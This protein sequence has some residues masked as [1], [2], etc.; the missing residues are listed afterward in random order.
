M[1]TNLHQLL[2]ERPVTTLPQVGERLGNLLSKLGIYQVKDLLFHLPYRYE[3][4]T[5]TTP[6]A[7]L[8]MRETALVFGEIVAVRTYHKPRRSLSIRIADDTGVMFM[9]LFHYSVHQREAFERGGWIRCFGEAKY[10]RSYYEMIHPEYKIFP[11][12]QTDVQSIELTPVYRLTEGIRQ[13]MM[14]RTVKKALDAC[15]R[16][17]VPDLL[18]P[19]L[20]HN[21]GF[22]TLMEAIR[23]VHSPPAEVQESKQDFYEQPAMKRLIMEELTSFQVARKQQKALRQSKSAPK[24]LPKGNLSLRLKDSLHFEPTNSQR[25]VI[26]EIISDL[27]KSIPMQRLVQGD[28][29]SG[30]TLVAAA[31]AAWVVD[32]GY[33]VA[34]MAP[35][36][37]LAE[38]HLTS[39]L[40]WFGPLGVDVHLLKG[41]L[42]AKLRRDVNAAIKFGKAN[43]VIGTHAL[44][45]KDVE[46]GNLGLIIVDEQHRF[47]VGQR[48]ALR[49]KGVL[50]NSAPH[51]LIMTATPIPRTLAMTFYAELDVSSITELPP[52]RTPVTTQI[53]SATMRQRVFDDIERRCKRGEQ[54]YW[55]CPIIEQSEYLEAAAAMDAEKHLKKALPNRKVGLIHGRMK[56]AQ[57]DRIMTSFRNGNVDVLVATTIIEVGVDVP[58]ASLMVIESA[59]RLGLAQLHQLRG[60]V[61]RGSKK[62]KCVLMF[63]G[64]L[65]ATAKE[66]LFVMCE[67]SDGFE[68]AETDLKHRGAGELL[69]T[70][71]TGVQLFH[72]AELPRD[73]KLLPAVNEAT[74]VIL[75]EYPETVEPLI[76]RWAVR[77]GRYS[78]V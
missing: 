12:P 36:E 51:Q 66:R 45:Q 65:S 61:G 1:G 63:K 34:I 30:K 2:E 75:R 31:A 53:C 33:Q 14:R 26:H 28:V 3:D 62:A 13:S 77:E 44:F 22:P 29:G 32:S 72:T 70:R 5:Q 68:I 21:L 18:P 67:T 38:Q 42:S 19:Q 47:G 49:E 54:A 11:S 17:G 43:I 40:E 35:T 58:N 25:I 73:M 55:V 76:R 78:A 41:K 52:G 6:I 71:Q 4:K 27:K 39:F 48:F 9:R 57:R 23:F 60:R 20:S 10:V 59:E 15:D 24:M 8:K 37:L 16:E 50:G 64:R 7:H 69:G 46:F 56:N 74:A